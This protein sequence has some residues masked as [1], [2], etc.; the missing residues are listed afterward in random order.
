MHDEFVVD[1]EMGRKDFLGHHIERR[2]GIRESDRVRA[3]RT[4]ISPHTIH[5]TS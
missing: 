1:T 4:E 5:I 3:S 2:E